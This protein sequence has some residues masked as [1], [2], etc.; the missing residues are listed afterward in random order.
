MSHTYFTSP[1]ENANTIE[2][3]RVLFYNS[4]KQDLRVDL[5]AHLNFNGKM[6]RSREAFL[7]T[8]ADKL[9]TVYEWD[10]SASKLILRRK[11]E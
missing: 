10:I 7:L 3:S 5:G 4:F 9:G 6:S 11:V 8:A 1:R 2:A